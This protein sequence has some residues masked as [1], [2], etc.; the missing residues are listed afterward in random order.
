MEKENILL[1]EILRFDNLREQYPDRRIKLRFNKNWYWSDEDGCGWFDYVQEYRDSRGAEDSEFYKSIFSTYSEKVKRLQSNEIVFQFIETGWNE[2]LF[3]DVRII[4]DA[5][6]CKHDS[7]WIYAKA[8]R[9]PG[10]EQ[11]LGRMIVGKPKDRG[12]YYVSNEIVD[13]IPVWSLTWLTFLERA[14][15]FDGYEKICKRYKELK[16][17]M[18]MNEWWSALSNVFGVYVIT[19]RATGRKYVG[20]AYG[21]N[22][23]AGRWNE[24]LNSGYDKDEKET[25]EYPNKK[26]KAL[27]NEKGLGYIQENFQYALLEIFPKNET[28]RKKALE[29][30]SY[31]KEVLL[32]RGDFGYNDN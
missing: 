31:W 4:V 17:I 6:G 28:G 20:S 30:E 7:G 16:H 9:L 11:F 21:E 13:S 1:G 26:L 5:D 23:V 22:G 18:Q 2:W 25:G 14:E 3:V 8:E 12:F 32:T 10:Y 29:R 15:T 19:D 27:V 24:Y